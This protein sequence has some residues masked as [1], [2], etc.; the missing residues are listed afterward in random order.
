[1]TEV[2]AD[3]DDGNIFRFRKLHGDIDGIGTHQYFPL[4]A[5]AYH[6][7]KLCCGGAAVEKN[8]IPV[9]DTVVSRI[10]DGKLFCRML[11][12][13]F[14]VGKFIQG[15]VSAYGASPCSFHQAFLFHGCQKLPDGHIGYFEGFA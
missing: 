2:T 8:R 6:P 9:T 15:S 13:F 7:G 14:L 5:A 10:S 3:H 4:G 1:M 12:F 11:P